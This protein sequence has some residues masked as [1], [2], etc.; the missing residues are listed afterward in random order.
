MQILE[1]QSFVEHLVPADYACWYAHQQVHVRNWATGAL[2][3]G[4]GWLRQTLAL[5]HRNILNG[6][7]DLGVFWVRLV[8]YAM[9][10]LCL[11]FVFFQL[12]NSW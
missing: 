3:E 7:R 9:L 12:D 6:A 1:L 4:S 8:M 5:T 11:G 10:C 2:Q